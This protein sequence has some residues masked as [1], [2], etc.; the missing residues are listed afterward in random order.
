MKIEKIYTLDFRTDY[1]IGV[2]IRQIWQQ[3]FNY[4]WNNG[5]DMDNLS[6]LLVDYDV[7]KDGIEKNKML[8]DK[9]QA[10]N[11]YTFGWYFNGFAT[12]MVERSDYKSEEDFLN[13][14]YYTFSNKMIRCDVNFEE[15]YAEFFLVSID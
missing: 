13:T 9:L 7:L 3:L 14:I 8:S 15:Q 12:S 6:N 5:G 11:T 10:S 4:Y 2:T 1:S